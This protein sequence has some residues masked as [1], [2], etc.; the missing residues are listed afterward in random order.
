MCR[1][2]KLFH[3]LFSFI[4]HQNP[5]T[6]D[7]NVNSDSIRTSNAEMKNCNQHE[8]RTLTWA[9]GQHRSQTSDKGMTGSSTDFFHGKS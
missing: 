7:G 3:C 2:V 9:T 5:D 4:Y 1:I 8:I 6:L